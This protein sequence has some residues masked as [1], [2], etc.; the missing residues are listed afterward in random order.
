M[1]QQDPINV[2]VIVAGSGGAGL[3]A[4]LD[5]MEQGA[6]V[7]IVERIERTREHKRVFGQRFADFA[8]LGVRRGRR[9]YERG[10]FPGV[11]PV[12]RIHQAVPSLAH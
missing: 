6:T 12:N 9:N 2:D 8:A 10:N 4:A 11:E 7:A 3:A 1:V 5:A